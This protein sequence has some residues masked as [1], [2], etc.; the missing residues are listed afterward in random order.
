MFIPRLQNLWN[1]IDYPF[2]KQINDNDYF[3]KDIIDIDIENLNDINEGDVVALI[4][5][6]DPES[7]STLLKSLS[8]AFRNCQL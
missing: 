3:F 1:S 8:T 5:D 6:F 7:I 2:L 4:G